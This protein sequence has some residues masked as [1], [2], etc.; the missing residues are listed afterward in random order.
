[1]PGTAPHAPSSDLSN[2]PQAVAASS[3]PTVPAPV[4]A[5]FAL[6]VTA[7]A[8]GVFETAL[9][10]GRLLADDSTSAAELAVGLSTRLVVFTTAILVALRMRRGRNWA[11]IALALG[12]GLAGT[13]SMVAEPIRALTRGGGVGLADVGAA[14]LAFGA[15][16][17]LHVA[18]VLFAVVLMFLPAAGSHFRR[19]RTVRASDTP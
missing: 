19:D 6:W 14:D 16:R 9:M 10:A 15:S 12:L 7:V 4:R 5:A 11:R 8:A 3:P 13:A 18:A 1:M 17:V 2:A